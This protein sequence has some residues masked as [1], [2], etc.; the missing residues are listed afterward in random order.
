MLI[1]LEFK[2]L[3]F[4]LNQVK[5]KE[6]KKINQ[7]RTKITCNLKILFFYHKQAHL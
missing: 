4:N 5:R 3:N 6:E 7:F 2:K 1:N